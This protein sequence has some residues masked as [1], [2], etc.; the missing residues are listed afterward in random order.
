[1]AFSFLAVFGRGAVVTGMASKTATRVCEYLAKCAKEPNTVRMALLF[2]TAPEGVSPSKD[3]IAF[4][5]AV[6]DSAKLG[7]ITSTDD[8]DTENWEPV[9]QAIDANIGDRH[10]VLITCVEDKD[11]VQFIPNRKG[12]TPA[13]V[14]ALVEDIYLQHRDKRAAN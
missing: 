4:V 12:D 9:M 11:G 6:C 2:L 7:W 5:S 14:M 13:F 1:M 8:G 10:T 3:T